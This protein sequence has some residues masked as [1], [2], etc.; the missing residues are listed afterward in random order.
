MAEEKKD[1]TRE[2]LE[3]MHKGRMEA[4]EETKK[5]IESAMPEEQEAVKELMKRLTDELMGLNQENRMLRKEIKQAVRRRTPKGLDD[6]TLGR[7][8]IAI[9]TQ[10][11]VDDAKPRMHTS[12]NVKGAL[13]TNTLRRVMKDPDNKVLAFFVLQEMAGK[14]DGYQRMELNSECVWHLFQE[15]DD[16]LK[17]NDPDQEI[18]TGD[19]HLDGGDEDGVGCA[20]AATTK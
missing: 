5:I 9:F 16:S 18:K 8:S 13:V 4:E 11:M 3:T 10:P 17:K 14:K 7:Y 20:E 12:D 6:V 15:L 2:E 1:M 19:D